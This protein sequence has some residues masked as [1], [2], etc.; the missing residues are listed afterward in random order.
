[1]KHCQNCNRD[2]S[3]KYFRK[4]CRSNKHL[5]MAFENKYLYKSENILF[6][7]VDNTLANIIKKHKPKFHSFLIVCKINNK[8]IMGYPKRV[9]LK[10]YDKDEMIN[11]EFNF[12]SI[13]ENMTFNHYISQP[14][15][16]LETLLI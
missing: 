13:K 3:D 1:M 14:K 9:L 16:M 7:E 6:N 11:V 12:Y 5:K 4:H 2:Y 8:K 15:A 10:N